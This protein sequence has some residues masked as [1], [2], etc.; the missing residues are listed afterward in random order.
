MAAPVQFSERQLVARTAWGEARGEGQIGLLAVIHVIRNR[1][2]WPGARW[3]GATYGEVCLKPQQFSC[4]L[5]VDPNYRSLLEM[6]ADD[7]ALV[8]IG[9]LVDRVL[10]RGHVDPTKG[11]T[12]Y[13]NRSTVRLPALRTSPER[14][15]DVDRSLPL[16]ARANEPLMVIGRHT[17][18]R[19]AP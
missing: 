9:E 19:I 10:D 2:M 11:A 7:P 17:F 1:V 13:L 6:R 8:A 18:W 16:W 3:W 12:H 5:P 15:G 4:W 14:D